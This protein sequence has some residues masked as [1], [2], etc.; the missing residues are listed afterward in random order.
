M[1]GPPLGRQGPQ[2][3]RPGKLEEEGLPGK[4]EASAR[5]YRLRPKA[6]EGK[7]M[8]AKQPR[9]PPGRG[10]DAPAETLLT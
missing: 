9:E 8:G 5:V 3:R 10:A 4:V 2:S 7:Q 6:A 1:P